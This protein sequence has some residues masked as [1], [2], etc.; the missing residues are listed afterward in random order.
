MEFIVTSAMPKNPGPTLCLN[1]IVKNE[2]RILTRLFDAVVDIIDCYC[3]CDT[4]STDNTPALIKEYFLAKGIPGKVV[5]EP[6]K[7]FAHNRNVALWAC[8]GMSD[9]VLLLDADMI[10]KVSEKFDKKILSQDYYYIFQGNEIFYY[11]NVRIVKNNGLYAYVGVTH[12]Y[13]NTP[14]GSRGGKVFDKKIIFIHDIGDGGA[15]S[16][17][18]KRDITLLEKGL[19][20]EPNNTRY[21]Y[22]LGNSYRDY[23]DDDKA[24]TTYIKQLTLNSWVQE[25]FCACISIGNI[26]QKKGELVNAAKYWLK[27]SEYDNERIE[28]VVKAAEHYRMTGEHVVVNLLY[29][30]YQNSISAYYASD[31]ECGYAC[32]KQILL[33]DLMKIELLQSTLSNLRFYKELLLQEPASE[34]EKL[35]LKVD[36]LLDKLLLEKKVVKK[37]DDDIWQLLHSKVE[38]SALLDTAQLDTAQLDT[39]QL[40]TALSDVD[41]NLVD[42]YKRLKQYRIDSKHVE[43]MDLYHTF[44]KNCAA[45][46][47]QLAYEYTVIAY[48]RGIRDINTQAVTILNKCEDASTVA[49]LLSNMKFYQSILQAVKEYDF[50]HEL[51]HIINNVE[52]TFHSSS[53]CILNDKN[54]GYLLNVRFVN[55]RI[56]SAGCYHDCTTHI[57]TLNKCMELTEDFQINSETVLSVDYGDGKHPVYRHGLPPKRYHWYCMRRL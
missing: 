9:Y 12:E 2:S 52:Y 37:S 4:G 46:E 14:A 42:S 29:N 48:Y 41:I 47:W 6:F 40:D 33:N 32:C 26:Y 38:Q 30:K 53:S 22:Y 19:E 1:M 15:K 20:E 8:K 24:L 43:A 51:K 13:M 57:I 25:K 31:K 21:Y 50:T 5:H 7:N 56:D 11:Q 27:A 28:G 44:P 55:Y 3:I 49:S 36:S 54:N 16:D 45:Y 23:G 17:K 34:R 10:L 35:F 39:A 18:F